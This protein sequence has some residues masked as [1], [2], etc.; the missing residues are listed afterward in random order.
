MKYDALKKKAKN[1]AVFLA[2]GLLFLGTAV[3]ARAEDYSAER[4]GSIRIQLKD[5]GTGLEQVEFCVYPVGTPFVK[6]TNVYWALNQELESTGVDLN[7]LTTGGQVREAAEILEDAV[8]GAEIVPE[9]GY[10]DANGTVT[11]PEMEQ[12]VY[13]ICQTENAYGSSEPSLV[14]VPGQKLDEDGTMVGWD[15]D[16]EITPKSEPPKPSVTPSPETTP[17]PT[18]TPSPQDQ[19]ESSPVKTGDSSAVWT[20]GGIL[21]LAGE[22]ILLSVTVVRKRNTER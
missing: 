16:V 21:L 5:L 18:V 3:P 20:W 14:S 1:F 7:E 2:A 11:F 22:L 13:L 10:T 6:D 17:G 19:R 12:G 9:K 8:A 4:E 15:Y